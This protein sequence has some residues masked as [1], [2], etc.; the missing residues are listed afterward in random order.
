MADARFL[1]LFRLHDEC[2]QVLASIV[3]VEVDGLTT[4]ARFAQRAGRLDNS[5]YKNMM[6]LDC[7]YHMCRHLTDMKVKG[8]LARLHARITAMLNPSGLVEWWGLQWLSSNGCERWT[9]TSKHGRFG[10]NIVV[11]PGTRS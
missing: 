2:Y 5:D 4:A 1:R 8:T 6:R 10:N 3:D 9:V 11:A 7:A